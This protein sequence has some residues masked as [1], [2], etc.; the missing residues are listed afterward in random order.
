[1]TIYNCITGH[2]PSPQAIAK[3][4][5]DCLKIDG[6]YYLD[7]KKV[8]GMLKDLVNSPQVGEDHK[9]RAQSLLDKGFVD[10]IQKKVE[11]IAL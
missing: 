3:R 6:K 11:N 8:N 1:M 7:I 10:E 5:F 2:R 4:S 9:H